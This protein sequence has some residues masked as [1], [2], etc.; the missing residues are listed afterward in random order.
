V[1]PVLYD[2]GYGLRDYEYE[3]E[4]D[5]ELWLSQQRRHENID[6]S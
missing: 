4:Y 5:E 3:Y 2:Y 1:K 6:I